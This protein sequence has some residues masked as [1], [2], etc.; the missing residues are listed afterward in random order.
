MK[1][2]KNT[3][4]FKYSNDKKIGTFMDVAG[5]VPFLF[6]SKRKREEDFAKGIDGTFKF[7]L[8]T[9]KSIEL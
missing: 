1:E 2:T 5:L 3:V 4:V 9:E 7:T 8:L 6:F